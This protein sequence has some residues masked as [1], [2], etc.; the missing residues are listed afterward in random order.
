MDLPAPVASQPAPQGNGLNTLSSILGIQ[1]QRQALQTGQ[2][3][4]AT[5][6]AESQQA[7]QKNAELQAVGNLTKSAYTSGRYRAADGSFDNQKFAQDVNQVAPTYGGTIANEATSRAGEIYK[8]QQTLFNLESSKRT[9]LGETLG[10]LAG[11]QDVTQSDV[12]DTLEGLRQ[13]H[14]D[15][16]GLSRLL[17]STQGMIPPNATGPQLQQTLNSIASGMTAK[18]SVSGVTN[19]AGQ[20]QLAGTYSGARSMP[21]LGGGATNPTTPQVAGQ[22]ARQ[23]GVAGSDVDR[24]NQVSALVQPSGA[25][26]PLTQHIDELAEQIHSGKFAASISK[27]A[28]AAGLSSETYARQILEKELGQVKTLAIANAGSDARAATIQSGYPEASSDTKT[29]HTAMDYVRGNFRQN[30]ARGDQLNSVRSKDTSLQGFQHADDVLTGSTDP[31]MHEFKSLKTP[32]ERIAFYQRNFTDPTRAQEFKN[33]VA[34]MGHVFG[35]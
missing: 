13:Q 4:Q 16:K 30:V 10:S 17:Q 14:P 32:Q 29:I 3:A 6:Q 25:A 23:G 5:A 18:P 26:I 31:L 27:A 1:Q 11:K 33:K 34:G 28:A 24:A 7:Q 20:S 2:Y 22:T 21:Q 9:Q 8:N 19:A 12:I 35:Q 15:D